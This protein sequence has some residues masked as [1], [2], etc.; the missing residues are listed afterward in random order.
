MSVSSKQI[1][2]WA[3]IAGLAV[4][5]LALTLTRVSDLD[6]GFYLAY[7]R[8]CLGRGIPR[9]EFY[10]PLL[11]GQTWSSIWALGALLLTAAWK[12]AGPAGLVALKAVGYGGAF[13]LVGAAGRR[14]GAP[15]WLAV[16]VAAAGACAVQARFVG[17]PGLVSA[18]LLGGLGWVAA[19]PRMPERVTRHPWRIGAALTAVSI[20]WSLT[21]AEWHV[22]VFCFAL[23]W[24]GLAAPLRIRVLQIVFVILAPLATHAVLQP[25]GVW[26]I[27]SPFRILLGGAASFQ[28]AEYS[29][30]AWLIMPLAPVML[31]MVF[32]AA[33]WLLTR[34]RWLEAAMIAVLALVCLKV[35]RAALPAIIVGLP[36]V[37]EAISRVFRIGSEWPARRVTLIGILVAAAGIATTAL[38]PYEDFGFSLDP[39]LDV[40]GTG[41]T[42]E[43][44]EKPVG[45]VLAD[46][47]WSSLLLSQPSVVRQGVIMDGRQEAYS[48]SYYESVYL[49]LLQFDSGWT[50]RA[51]EAGVAFYFEPWS[52]AAEELRSTRMMAEVRAA[53]WKLI[54]WDNAGRLA[55][56]PDVVDAFALQVFHFDP[57]ELEGVFEDQATL[58]D[59]EKEIRVRCEEL[60]E[61]EFA[62]SRGW[63]I[64]A[65]LAA[66]MGRLETALS[67]LDSARRQGGERFLRYWIALA[68]TATA[69]RDWEAMEAAANEVER[70]G[71]PWTADALRAQAALQRGD[72]AAAIVSLQRAAQ[73][74][75]PEEA[76]RYKVM[77]EKLR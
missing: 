69:A 61:A 70:R 75:P 24:S 47:G 11:R 64:E 32:A 58:V 54:G 55:A 38:T 74:A 56:R 65:R 34:K 21:H 67:S 59:A 12:V 27:L 66:R 33:V 68:E 45:P 20:L 60:A 41:K 19:S 48:Q 44:V 42:L 72:F 46:F 25:A 5:L 10:L 4:C 62:A 35:T 8:E 73:T 52:G 2:R 13:A 30:A 36:F 23:L 6:F 16:L 43:A 51:R 37:A 49:P 28:I 18:F 14:R 7:G 29:R 39:I 50:E 71:Q 40:R 53:G 57:D 9:E 26:P 22:G 31:V 63:I 76:E 17:R 15:M 3:L 77:L 1:A